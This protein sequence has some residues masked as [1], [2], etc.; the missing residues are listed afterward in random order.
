MNVTIDDA[1]EMVER[2]RASSQRTETEQALIVL[3]AHMRAH[4]RILDD[5]VEERDKLKEERNVATDELA[6]V[7]EQ[8]RIQRLASRRLLRERDVA[9]KALDA[10][11]DLRDAYDVLYRSFGELKAIL[12]ATIVQRDKFALIAEERL[13]ALKGEE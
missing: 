1:M 6:Q 5:L 11:K 12:D 2:V 13:A 8:L 9:R 7:R 10:L 4:G 3:E